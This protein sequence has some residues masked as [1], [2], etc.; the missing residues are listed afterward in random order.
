MGYT[1]IAHTS[2]VLVSRL[3][4]VTKELFRDRATRF[5]LSVSSYL[6]TR[7]NFLI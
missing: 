4:V 5:L 2:S 7:F 3:Q 1:P 6:V